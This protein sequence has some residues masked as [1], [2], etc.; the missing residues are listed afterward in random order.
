MLLICLK[1]NFSHAPYQS[2]SE[3]EE[4]AGRMLSILNDGMLCLMVSIGHKARLFDTMSA[5][6]PATS[7]EIA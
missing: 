1:F 6:P 2:M 3:Q 4:F 5:M 7:A